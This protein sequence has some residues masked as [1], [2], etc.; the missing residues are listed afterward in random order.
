MDLVL[1]ETSLNVMYFGEE[2]DFNN[3]EDEEDSAIGDTEKCEKLNYN[4]NIVA[5]VEKREL[6]RNIKPLVC[7]NILLEKITSNYIIVKQII[8]NL[9]WQ[10]KAMCKLVC[11]NWYSAVQTLQKEQISPEDFVIDLCYS[12]RRGGEKGWFKK[13]GIF[14][15]EPLVIFTFANTAG[16]SAVR[17]CKVIQPRP[18]KQHCDQEHCLINLINCHVNA[19]KNCMLT[20]KA[21]Y[22]VYRPRPHSNTYGHSIAHY[23]IYTWTNPLIA[24]IFIPKIP[25]VSFQ[26]L[27]IRS[28]NSLQQ[29]F[30]DVVDKLSKEHIIKGVLVFF[31]EKYLLDSV[32]DI[33]FLNYFKDVQPN[34]PYALGGCI[35]EDTMSENSD[36]NLLVDSLNKGADFISE[37]LLSIGL[38]TIPKKSNNNEYNFE[39]YSFIIESSDWTKP[40]IQQLVTEFSKKVPRFEHSIALK[41]SCVDRD[42]KHVLEQDCFRAAFPNTTIVGCYGNGGLGIHHPAIPEPEAT[43]LRHRRESFYSIPR[44]FGIMYFN[45]TVFVYIGWGKI[46]SPQGPL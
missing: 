5:F 22:L 44:Q 4:E 31:T 34:V 28:Q 38:F 7:S 37:N 6:T 20:V 42:K 12:L 46:I 13:S 10:D 16:F 19:P 43:A 25:D 21:T 32:E 23:T 39:M 45:S 36:I 33:V 1:T 15:T 35:V 18:C 11:N 26:V 41:F 2:E 29:E 9:S 8:S 14:Y 3:N 40:D 24:G 30:Y 17:K 27:N